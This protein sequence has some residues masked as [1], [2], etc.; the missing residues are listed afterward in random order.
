M[1]YDDIMFEFLFK[2]LMIDSTTFKPDPEKAS[3]NAND[4]G[5]PHDPKSRNLGGVTGH[6]GIFTNSE[7][8][9]NLK[10]NSAY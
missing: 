6:A 8:L 4:L 2:P 3:G 9:D 7:G 10:K 5:L 1:K